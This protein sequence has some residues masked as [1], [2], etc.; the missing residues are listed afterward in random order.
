MPLLPA[1][2]YLAKN[3]TKQSCTGFEKVTL[4]SLE[5]L[6]VFHASEL[7]QRV[8]LHQRVLAERVSKFTYYL[9][10]VKIQSELTLLNS[11]ILQSV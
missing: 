1:S 10:N 2:Y 8:T 9:K 4:L 7:N 6:D 11:L 3:P 5:L